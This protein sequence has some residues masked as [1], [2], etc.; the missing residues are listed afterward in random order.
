MGQAADA[1]ALIEVAV[2][3]KSSIRSPQLL[4]VIEPFLSH[5]IAVAVVA[6]QVDPEGIVFRFIPAG[7]NVQAE[8]PPDI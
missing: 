1:L 4:D 6:G 8:S 5:C 2:P 3:V 7:D